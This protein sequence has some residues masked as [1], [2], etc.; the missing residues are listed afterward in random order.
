MASELV[1]WIT[2]ISGSVEESLTIVESFE[3]YLR[4][5]SLLTSVTELAFVHDGTYIRIWGCSTLFVHHH[6]LLNFIRAQLT[7]HTWKIVEQRLISSKESRA[8]R[9]L[10][11]H[12]EF[13]WTSEQTLGTKANYPT[14]LA[15]IKSQQLRLCHRPT[16]FRL[17]V[18]YFT[19]ITSH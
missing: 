15:E 9:A 1:T 2:V 16:W 8:Y 10:A 11:N 5:K 13:K 19:G 12:R 6:L 7:V 4:E 14:L 18:A 17:L 3:N